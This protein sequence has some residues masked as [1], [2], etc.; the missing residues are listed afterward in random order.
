MN[1]AYKS[2]MLVMWLVGWLLDPFASFVW[3]VVRKYL[4]EMK[5]DVTHSSLNF[6]ETFKF[7]VSTFHVTFR[8][9]WMGEW[10][11]MWGRFYLL[12]YDFCFAYFYFDTRLL[13]LCWKKSVPLCWNVSIFGN[14]GFISIGGIP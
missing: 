13:L 14:V 6:L 11:N 3:V 5:T 8:R 10:S 4:N 9:G 2:F 12:L 7:S 1:G